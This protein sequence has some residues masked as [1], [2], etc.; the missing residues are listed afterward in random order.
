M[1]FG[2]VLHVLKHLLRSVMLAGVEKFGRN[3]GMGKP[4]CVD[5]LAVLH[6]IIIIGKH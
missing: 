4:R 6:I 2:G 5:Y 1:W 3:I